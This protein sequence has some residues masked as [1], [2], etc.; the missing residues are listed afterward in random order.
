[1]GL[2]YMIEADIIRTVIRPTLQELAILGAIPKLIQKAVSVY[3]CNKNG[4]QLFS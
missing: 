4:Y 3:G 1:M 2:E